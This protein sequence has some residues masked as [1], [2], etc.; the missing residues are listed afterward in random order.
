[1]RNGWCLKCIFFICFTESTFLH[2][3]CRV[4]KIYLKHFKSPKSSISSQNRRTY[5]LFLEVFF[6]H[7]KGSRT[8][9]HY[10]CYVCASKFG[11]DVENLPNAL[12]FSTFLCLLRLGLVACYFFLRSS[13]PYTYCACYSMFSWNINFVSGRWRN[14]L[15]VEQAK[16]KRTPL[17]QLLF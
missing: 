1:M 10:L 12:A 9:Y 16:K 15:Y 7:I 8:D 6:L 3:L 5:C 14:V 11:Y 13:F 4:S 2:T 17:W